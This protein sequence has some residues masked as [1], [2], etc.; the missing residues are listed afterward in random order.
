MLHPCQKVSNALSAPRECEKG[1]GSQ[2]RAGAEESQAHPSREQMHHHEGEPVPSGAHCTV[3]LMFCDFRGFS[4]IPE[5]F[6][7]DTLVHLL[8]EHLAAMT[9]TIFDHEGALDKC[10]GD[11]FLAVFG[12]MRSAED[13]ALRCVDAA[14][15]MQAR[16][17]EINVLRKS[18]DL[19]AFGLGIGI[20]TGRVI[21]GYLG[22]SAFRVLTV[23]G[24]TVNTARRLCSIAMPGQILAD[25][26]TYS[27]VSSRFRATA[28]GPVALR[29]RTRFVNPYM[30]NGSLEEK[31]LVCGQG[32]AAE[33]RDE[34]PWVF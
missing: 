6:P 10:S 21:A 25:A 7:P 23:V 2:P 8:N 28:V 16:N 17:R 32:A 5:G 9:K 31:M 19:P 12:S 14:L 20:K 4:R 30:I 18:M 1:Q 3:T 34:E 13:D 15:T 11:E 24:D 26:T 22:P 27:L 33:T 29:G